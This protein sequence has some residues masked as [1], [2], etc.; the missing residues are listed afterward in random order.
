MVARDLQVWHTNTHSLT[1]IYIC[2]YVPTLDTFAP[3]H[4]Q[5]TPTQ[6]KVRDIHYVN[7]L[8]TCLA[9]S[10]VQGTRAHTW[11]LPPQL[12]LGEVTQVQQQFIR[13]IEA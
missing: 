5:S 9:V 7:K 8:G 1:N 12:Y 10:S 13:S 3:T 11:Q 4:S 6:T 2:T